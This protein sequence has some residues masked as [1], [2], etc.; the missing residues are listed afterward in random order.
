MF[1]TLVCAVPG[2]I[3]SNYSEPLSGWLRTFPTRQIFVIQ[4][5]E[6][7]ENPAKVLFDLKVFLGLD[8]EQPDRDFYNVN[9]RQ[10]RKGYP[11]K[12]GQYQRLVRMVKDDSQRVAEMLDQYGLA[13][14]EAW[15][16]RWRATWDNVLQTC[17]FGDNCEVDSN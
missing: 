15:L 16:A 2:H 3:N 6:L 13:N 1:V 10:A 5:E 9:S 4:F 12:R 14:Q 17:D 7:Q 8:P 11:I